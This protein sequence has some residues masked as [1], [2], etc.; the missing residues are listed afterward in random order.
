MKLKE[1]IT[2]YA[3][4]RKAIGEGFESAES[5]LNTFWRYMGVEIEVG[6]IR[7]ERVEAFLAGTGPVNRYWRRKYDTLRGLYRYATSRGFADHVPLPATVPKMPERFVP[8]IYNPNE[9]ERLIHPAAPDQIGFRKQNR[10]DRKGRGSSQTKSEAT[11]LVMEPPLN[12]ESN[13]RLAYFCWEAR[14]CQNGSAEVD[15]RVKQVM[16]FEI[17]ATDRQEVACRIA[18]R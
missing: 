2:Q 9:L 4:F 7:A 6:E 17:R 1:L 12:Q 3:A 11:D 16:F 14:G 10:H 18:A 13:A 5:L 8:Y 15:Y